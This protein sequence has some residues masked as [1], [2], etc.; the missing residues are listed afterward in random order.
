MHIN[1]EVQ[2]YLVNNPHNPTGYLFQAES[3]LP[4]VESGHLV[5]LDEAF[6]DFIPPEQAQ[7]LI[8]WVKQFPNLVIL[9]SLTKFYSLPG[10]RIGY[11]IAHPD[12]LQRWQRWRDPWPVNTLAEAATLAA[13]QDQAFQLQTWQWLPSARQA[14][15]DGL[16]TIAGL[17][18]WAGT[19]NFL[20]VRAD[21]AVPE[22]QERLLKCHHI[23][24][25]DCLS[26]PELGDRYFRIAVRTE[27]ENQSLLNALRDVVG[28]GVGG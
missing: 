1:G 7:S 24:V 27:V 3:L 13:L 6:M 18:P 21:R 17:Y 16:R 4:L 5:V 26:F 8:P 9:R 12:R 23:L 20:L 25:R 28:E 11:A 2:G 10:L 19:A 22:L 15:L 14:L